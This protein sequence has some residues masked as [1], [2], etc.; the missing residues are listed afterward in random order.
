MKESEGLLGAELQDRDFLLYVWFFI[1]L[2][3][4]KPSRLRHLVPRLYMPVSTAET[5]TSLNLSC[6]G[7]L[8]EKLKVSRTVM[9]FPSFYETQ[10][11][12]AM[13]TKAQYWSPFYATR[14]CPHSSQHYPSLYTNFYQVISSRLSNFS[15]QNFMC[16]PKPHHSCY[17]HVPSSPP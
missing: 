12:T 15:G 9:N 16:T 2:S 6:S 14:I 1:T 8:L 13:F 7:I 5:N 17:M 3:W 10:K 11:F 4:L